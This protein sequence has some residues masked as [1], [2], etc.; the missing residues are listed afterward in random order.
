MSGALANGLAL[1]ALTHPG[2]T[3]MALPSRFG[4]HSTYRERGYGGARGLRLV[5]IPCRSDGSI[6]FAELGTAARRERPR[7]IMVGTAWMLQPFPIG[8]LRKVADDVGATLIYDGAHILG[9]VAGGQFQNPLQE[10]AH[11]LT[12]STQKTLGGPIGGLVLSATADLGAQ[13]AKVTSGLI[14]NY[15]NNRIAALAVTLAETVAF[16]KSLASMIVDNARRLAVA[17]VQHGIPVVGVPP[18]YTDS[19]VVLVD[20]TRLPEGETSFRRLEEAGILTTKIPLANTYPERRAIRMGTPAITRSGMRGDDILAIAELI[21]RVLVD[22]EAP[23]SVAPDSS[24]LARKFA[25]V[26]YCFRSG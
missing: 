12:G 1:F 17:L 24:R 2:E 26:E 15:H 21:K 16:G 9:L 4:G 6:D 5:D 11:V 13:I 8:P 22:R 10:G 25:S 20:S 19:H 3:L 7:V 23:I 18:E 14:S